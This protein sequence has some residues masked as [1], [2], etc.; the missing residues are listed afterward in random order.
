M[1]GGHGHVM[2]TTSLLCSKSDA[3]VA[4]Q[5]STTSLESST[6]DSL[7]LDRQYSLGT[8]GSAATSSGPQDPTHSLKKSMS[9]MSKKRAIWPSLNVHQFVSF[10]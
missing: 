10:N 7:T 4:R 5:L 2:I 9:P 3:T 8:T 6:M 1:E